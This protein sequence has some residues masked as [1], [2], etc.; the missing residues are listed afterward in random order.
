MNVTPSNDVDTSKKS[1]TIV[2]NWLLDSNLSV[3]EKMVIIAI[4]RHLM[5]AEQVI[6]SHQVIMKT[7]SLSLSAVKRA[8]KSLIVKGIVKARSNKLDFKPNS[9]SLPRSGRPNRPTAKSGSSSIRP[10]ARGSVG[11]TTTNTLKPNT[12]ARYVCCSCREALGEIEKLIDENDAAYQ[13]CPKCQGELVIDLIRNPVKIDADSLLRIL[14]RYEA[15]DVFKA[16][17]VIAHKHKQGDNI[18]N[19]PGLLVSMLKFGII[20]PDGYIPPYERRKKEA[21]IMQQKEKGRAEREKAEAEQRARRLDAE[22]R[23]SM[24]SSEERRF[25]ETRA[26]NELPNMLRPYNRYVNEKMIEI[27]LSGVPVA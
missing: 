10:T 13:C 17:D 1:F 21:F 18:A 6:L 14:S 5:Q 11:A 16:L 8:L 15:V 25:L 19:V 24:L 3:H 27:I 26:R 20:V 7:A 22:T 2:D 23:L 9:Y 12:H 4:K